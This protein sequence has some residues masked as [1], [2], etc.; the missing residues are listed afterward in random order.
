MTLNNEQQKAFDLIKEGNS[1]LLTG[2]AGTGKSFTLSEIIL[3]AH[4]NKKN[5]GVTATTGSAALLIKGRT[6]HSFLGIGLA[7][8]TASQLAAYVIQNSKYVMNRLRNLNILIIDEISML[9]AELFTK[10]SEFLSIIR[11]NDAPFGGVQMIL[12]GD[13]AQIAPVGK[14]A[15]Y[16]F[17]S[18]IWQSSNIITINLK[19]IIRQKDDLEFINILESL[20]WGKCTKSILER[21]KTLQN[22]TFDSDILPTHLY[23][24][25]IDVDIIN[26]SHFSKLVESGA[27][28]KIYITKYTKNAKI[29]AD[30]CKVQS[31]IRLCIGAQ[32]VLTWNIDQ[33]LGLVN[34]SRGIVIGFDTNGP[35]IKFKNHQEGIPIA[36]VNIANEDNKADQITFMPIRLAWAI[37][38]HRS[39]GMTLDSCI[40]D[41]SSWSSGQAYT[42]LSR[43]RDL[44]SVKLIGEINPK[45][46]KINKDVLDFYKK[47]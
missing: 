26:L 12:C 42:A 11:M 47:I 34:G 27:E 10:I 18:D 2:S 17:K 31:E 36:Y 6:I 23:G 30:S 9:D 4:K 8:K 14:N 39:Q 22:T 7:T 33:E 1:I 46:F 45:C 44:K 28:T 32:V 37:T 13:F 40:I 41:L 15:E 29:W 19:T 43:V 24:K 21:L 38:H 20:R 25:N 16:C 3:W 5:I 35:I